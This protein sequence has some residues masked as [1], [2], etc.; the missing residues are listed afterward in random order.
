MHAIALV[1]PSSR[2]CILYS[3]VFWL[4]YCSV[5]AS[6]CTLTFVCRSMRQEV[7][8][9]NVDLNLESWTLGRHVAHA[10][11]PA[12]SLWCR[13][14]IRKTTWGQVDNGSK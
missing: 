13:L 9:V 2:F 10:R 7:V 5:V 11:G 4:S 6:G 12:R 8:V 3:C 1:R 14:P